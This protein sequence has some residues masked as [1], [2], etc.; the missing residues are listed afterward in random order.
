MHIHSYCLIFLLITPSIIVIII[1]ILHI[2][3]NCYCYCILIKNFVM[4]IQNLNPDWIQNR[5]WIRA[6][7]QNRFWIQSLDSPPNEFTS[8]DSDSGVASQNLKIKITVAINIDMKNRDNYDDDGGGNT[9]KNQTIMPRNEYACH[10]EPE[11]WSKAWLLNVF[12]HVPLICV[13]DEQ[14]VIFWGSNT[15]TSV[16]RRW[17]C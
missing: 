6:W 1:T 11:T 15:S 17:I 7:I 13:F 8:L 14:S 9:K 3:I 4:W 10:R 2:D 16:G 12:S 5:F